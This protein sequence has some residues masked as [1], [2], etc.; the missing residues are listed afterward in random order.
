MT[1]KNG[2]P[3]DRRELLTRTAPACAMTCLG[4]LK[5]RQLFA[6]TTE[7]IDQEV[8]KF[9]VPREFQLSRRR[10]IRLENTKF[11]DFVQDVRS[12]LGDRELIR[13][14]EI[15][16]AAL[17][18]RA[19]ERQ[20]ANSPDRNFQT[21]VAT[22]RPPR[23]VNSLTHEVVEDTER[24]FGLRVR[25][26]IWAEVFR[27]AGLDGEIGHAAVCNMDYYWPTAFHPDLRM[28][29]TKTLMRGDDH[30]NHRY[31]NTAV[32]E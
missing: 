18:R 16:S 12:E 10:Y 3:L 7:S 26:C 13:L 23:Y 20:A 9:D 22:F 14:L 21:F 31:I 15:H 1:I 30:C 6:A 11:I 8:H 19:G 2:T 24:A 17:G 4:M 29:R 5:A 25:E 32:E 28:E 27:E